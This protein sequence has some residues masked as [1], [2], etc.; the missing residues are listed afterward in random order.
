MS[1]S[2]AD[3]LARSRLTA[4]QLALIVQLDDKGSVLEAA[5]AAYMTQPAASRLLQ[6]LERSFG[7]A[8][9]E[10]HARGV[11]ATRYGKV[12]V[13]HAR[14]VLAEFRQAHEE[15]AALASGIVGDV[16]IGTTITSANDLV[17]IAVARL[18]EM[19][20][21]VRVGIEL[22]FS[23]TLVQQLLE[24]KLDL[25]IAR[26]HTAQQLEG[27]DFV[28]LGEEPHGIIA[29]NGH[30]LSGK[31]KLQLADI[32]GQAWVLPPPGNVM[33]DALTVLFLQTGI[34]LPQQVIE[35]AALPVTTSLLSMSDMIAPLAIEVVRPYL[36]ARVLTKLP[37]EFDVRLGAAGIVT[38]HGQELSPA[39][40]LLLKQLQGA[41]AQLYPRK[42]DSFAKAPRRSPAAGRVRAS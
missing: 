8:L 30:P 33:R 12:L 6:T 7:V 36:E 38:R 26:L 11:V 3:W 27:L 2:P 10:R 18:N 17:P 5:Q 16:R 39:A 20:P 35:T 41:A 31:K 25:A 14:A 13:R 24:R 28:P 22:G 15:V 4:R 37:V 1:S 32:A 34:D 23:E 9:F 29:R 21:R 42:P 19:Y 40:Q